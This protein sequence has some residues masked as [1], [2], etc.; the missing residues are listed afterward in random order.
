[1]GRGHQIGVDSPLGDT[2]GWPVRC[3][4]VG[5]KEAMIRFLTV[6]GSRLSTFRSFDLNVEPN[7]KFVGNASVINRPDDD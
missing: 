3:A 6:G 7:W 2:I 4:V 5:A 1:V